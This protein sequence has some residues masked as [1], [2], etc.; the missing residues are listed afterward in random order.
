MADFWQKTMDYKWVK[1]S[2]LGHFK[3]CELSTSS[4]RV[5]DRLSDHYKI[6]EIEQAKLKLEGFKDSQSVFL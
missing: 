3:T 1:L 5:F 2:K 6:I 4:C